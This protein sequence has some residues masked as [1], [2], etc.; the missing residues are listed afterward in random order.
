M[1]LLGMYRAANFS[2]RAGSKCRIFGLFGPGQ[3]PDTSL[4][5]VNVHWTVF[6]CVW[7]ALSPDSPLHSSRCRLEFDVIFE[8]KNGSHVVTHTNLFCLQ[9]K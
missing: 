6:E 3:K 7:K 8:N 5:S 1:S 2:G 4:V 9:K